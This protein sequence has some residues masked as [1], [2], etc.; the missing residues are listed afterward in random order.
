MKDLPRE[1]AVDPETPAYR[2][3]YTSLVWR[4]CPSRNSGL[5]LLCDTSTGRPRP[6]PGLPV[7]YHLAPPDGKI[8]VA[9][10]IRKDARTWAKQCLHCQRSKVGRH[11]ES[12]VGEFQARETLGHIHVDIVGP[13]HLQES[14]I[15]PDSRRPLH[16]V[17]RQ[18]PD[19]RHSCRSCGPPLT[20]L[21][22]TKHHTTTSYNPQPKRD[23]GKVSPF[24]KGL[25]TAR[26]SGEN[27]KDQLPWVLLGLRRTTAMASRPLPRKSMGKALTVPGE[28]VEGRK[29]IT[30]QRL[31]GDCRQICTFRRSFQALRTPVYISP[32]LSS[33]RQGLCQGRCSTEKAPNKSVQGPLQSTRRSGKAYQLHIH[34]REDWVSID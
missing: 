9:C 32:A 16:Q 24:T 27:W 23:G 30:M 2:T 15:H 11:T 6:N 13:Y 12:A 17:A 22:G 7:P 29:D 25:L 31:L 19:A 10:G 18:Q 8:H 5:T 3:A 33:C 26:C 21:L 14:Q 28:L 20:Q 4:T 34:G 1:Q